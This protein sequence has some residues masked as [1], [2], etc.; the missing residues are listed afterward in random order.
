MCDN[1]LDIFNLL[2]TVKDNMK[3]RKD[4]VYLMIHLELHS[5]EGSSRFPD[6]VYRHTNEKKSRI[7]LRM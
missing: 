5:Y 1:V 2:G 3:L 7:L 6:A 4:L